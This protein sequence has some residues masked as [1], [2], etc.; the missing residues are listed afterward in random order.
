MTNV[1]VVY[2]TAKNGIELYFESKPETSVI[3]MMKLGGFRWSGKQKMWYARQS[4]K[5]RYIASQV[6]GQMVENVASEPVNPAEPYDLWKMTLTDGIGNNVDKELQPK[7]IAAIIRKHIKERFPMCRL[8]FT[9]HDHNDFWSEVKAAPFA[10]DSEELKA[11]IDYITAYTHSFQYGDSDPYADYHWHNFYGGYCSA[12]YDYVET[13]Q[14]DEIADMI[15]R[16]QASK[17][18]FEREEEERKQR[19][20][21][22]MCAKRE[23]EHAEYERRRQIEEAQRNEVEAAAVTRD[24]EYFVENAVFPKDCKCNTLSLYER[25]IEEEGTNESRVCRV[26]REVH[27]TKALYDIFT[28][29]LLD[30]WSFVAGMGGSA[31]DDWRVNSMIDYDNMT[32]EERE[33][34][35]WFENECVA[36]FCDG[37]MKLIVNPEGYNYC[38]YVYLVGKET[39]VVNEYKGEQVMT[40][41]QLNEN[42]FAADV[43]EDTSAE[44]IESNGLIASWD[45]DNFGI[46]KEAMKRKIYGENGRP[47][48]RFGANIIRA[49]PENME[50]LKTA[51]YKLAAE[52]NSTQEQFAR[53]NPQPGQ[54]LTIIKMYDFGGLEMI[55]LTVKSWKKTAYAQYS[56]AVQL[57]YV[58]SR[59]KQQRRIWL[60]NDY[61]IF[62][63][64]LG[65]I[66]DNLIW[67]T[68]SE[69]GGVVMRRMRH[70]SFDR[71]WYDD[72]LAYYARLDHKP[73][74]NT[75]QPPFAK[76]SKN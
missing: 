46:Y 71:A 67:E 10:K 62:D 20:W 52:M 76:D 75:Y 14:T 64:W 13:A 44:V 54:R 15:Q 40:E 73:I 56:D 4:D 68:V 57:D 39:R 53:V 6:S 63:G 2:N 18:E 16:F 12:H 17:V 72:V 34:V 49:L 5:T 61:L 33:T 66:P 42:K 22:E 32:A 7:E 45:T 65:D 8:S 31:T 60:R 1:S 37:E 69:K 29:Q 11:I 55:R 43:L 24:V 3:D 58:P 59:G 41:E 38:R 35:E 51:M 19:E 23:A 21:A 27:L 74:I 48:I 47:G 70:S 28:S 25:S 26:T 9:V 50:K 30:D 36:V